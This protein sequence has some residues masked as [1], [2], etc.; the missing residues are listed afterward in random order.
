MKITQPALLFRNVDSEIRAAAQAAAIDRSQQAARL[1]AQ[2]CK[3]EAS[4]DHDLYFLAAMN[5]LADAY[6]DAV[7]A[8]TGYR[9]AHE[10]KQALAALCVVEQGVTATGIALA[11]IVAVALRRINSAADP[12]ALERS[13]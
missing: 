1:I 5:L 6:S 13:A 4:G 11:D 7:Q 9:L 8:L 10:D 2:A 3:Q 12:A